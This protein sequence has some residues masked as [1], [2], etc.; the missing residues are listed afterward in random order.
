M[1]AIQE[2]VIL[3]TGSTDGIGKQ[4]ACD[5]ALMG[6]TVLLHGRDRQRLEATQQVICLATKNGNVLDILIG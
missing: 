1:T 6:S 4:T 5:L 2:R 3:V